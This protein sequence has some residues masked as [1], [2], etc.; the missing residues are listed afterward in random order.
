M[1]YRRYWLALAVVIIGSFAVLG[2][3]GRKMISEAPPIPDVYSAGGQLL[4]TGSIHYRWARSMA[5]DR[6]TGDRHS[7]GSW[8]L[9]RARLERRLAAPG[10]RD[11]AEYLGR[12]S[13]CGEFRSSRAGPTGHLQSSPDSRDAHQHL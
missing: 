9:R 2:G 13:W 10:I 12:Q 8:S 6:R 11:S 7:L 5:V 1:N 3:V 4:F